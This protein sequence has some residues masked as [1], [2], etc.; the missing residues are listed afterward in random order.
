[1]RTPNI[2][3]HLA[4]A[5]G[6]AVRRFYRMALPMIVRRKIQPCREIP[7]DLFT[8]SG[9]AMLAEQVASIRSFLR[10]AGRPKQC[11]IYSDGSYTPRSIEL[12]EQID[13]V[14]K[15][16]KSSPLLSPQFPEELRSYLATH[17][18]G[19]QL[20]LI[21]SLPVETQPAL[22]VDSDV[23]FFS[24]ANDLVSL[25]EMRDAPALYLADCQ[26]AADERFFRDPS[27]RVHPVNTG[28]LLLF[29][30]LDWSLAIARFL[31]LNGAP[32]FFTNQTMTH[33]TMQANGA[34]PFDHRK[35]VLQLDDQFV[36]GDRYA[37]KSLVLR[38]YV[39][40]VRHKL[41]TTLLR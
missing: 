35:Y 37:G 7:V 30:S 3:Y 36:Y 2:G 9:E 4:R 19:K 20:A 24:G 15:V 12:L 14:V 13:P 41:W 25:I 26:V 6:D 38:H 22:Y 39:N 1:M 5:E 11:T 40:P 27:E 16:S 31:E 29:R 17:P 32:N 18:T 8:Y 28:F 34:L 23:L 33:L 21:M 10:Y